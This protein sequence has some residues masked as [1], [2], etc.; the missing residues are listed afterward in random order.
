MTNDTYPEESDSPTA[1][2]AP[3]DGLPTRR[4]R[5][6]VIAYY[7]PP[8]GLSGVLRIAKFC[9]YLVQH[10]WDPTVL[11]VGDVGYFAYDYSLLEE[12]L[13]AGVVIERT[14]TLDPLALFK[15]RGT[16]RLPKTGRRRFLSGITH[17]F[18]QP[19]NKIGWKRYALR[20]AAE[21]MEE[22]R[23]DVVLATAP[24]FTGFLIGEALQRRYGVP[25][26]LD[27]RDPWLDNKHYFFATPVHRRYAAGL[28]ESVLKHADSVVVVNRRIKEGLIARYPFLSHENVQIIPSG[29]DPQDFQIARRFPMEK[30]RRMRITF[31][32]IVDVHLKSPRQ[33]FSALAKI[34][35]KHPEARDEIELCFVGTFHE[36][37]R[38]LATDLGVG[39]S[40]VTPGYVDHIDAIRYLL[41]SDVLWLSTDDP[42]ITPGKIH[43]YVGTRKPIL[44]L[45]PPGVVRQV[46]HE[47]GAGVV[48]DPDDLDSIEE[49][50]NGLYLQW[51]SGTLP[52]GNQTM[53]DEYNQRHLVER[54]SRIL[55]YAI[56][57]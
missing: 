24:P 12:V 57:I 40:L 31:L 39:S 35:A 45:V 44:A 29:Y 30:S 48:A 25:L 55:S 46:L 7:F 27:Y 34:F 21:L 41:S 2:V 32:G 26:V 49:A 47:Y 14:K 10:G 19:D 18:L 17:T 43:E 36:S 38:K 4:G 50:V 53:A 11:T 37:Y 52:V 51:K 42:A 20:R 9:K 15:K 22:H 1:Q 13:E 8:M 16:I 23:F 54:L 56:K 33:F 28:E 3:D 5:V 6:L